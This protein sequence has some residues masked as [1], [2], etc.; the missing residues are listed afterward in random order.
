MANEEILELQIRD[1]AAYAAQGLGELST[2]LDKLKTAVGK[3]LRLKGVATQLE[4]LKNAVNSGLNEDS[5]ARFE[6]LAGVLERLKGIGAIKIAGI[7]NIASQMN[8]TDSLNDAKEQAIDTANTIAGAVDRGM[9]EVESRSTSVGN[10]LRETFANAGQKIKEVV[11]SIKDAVK[12][13]Y[14]KPGGFLNELVGGIKK[15]REGFKG[16][17]SDFMRIVKYRMIRS[18]IK[19]ITQAFTEG[20]KN[21]YFYSKEVGGTLAPAMDD[22]AS[23]LLQFKNSIGAA[24]SPLI[25]ELIPVLKTVVN[26]A[27]TG[28]NWLNQLF[29][30]MRGQHS[31]TKAIYK[32]TNAFDDQSKKAKKAGNSIKELLADWDELN[33]IQSESG[34]GNGGAAQAADDYTKMFE[35]E[36]KFDSWLSEHFHDVLDMIKAAGVALLGWKL[37]KNFTGVLGKLSKLIAGGAM[38]ALGIKLSFESGFDAGLN[39]FNTGNILGMI[40]G[41][42]ASGIGGYMITSAIGL[43]GGIGLAIGLG[44]GIVAS[45]YGYIK[46]KQDLADKSKWGNLT[47]TQ[48]QIERF[49]KNQF[50]FDIESEITIFDGAITNEQEAKEILNQKIAAFKSSLDNA[51]VEAKINIDSDE[52]SQ[53]VKDAAEKGIEAIGAV[54]QLVNASGEGLNVMLKSFKFTNDAGDDITKELLSSVEIANTTVES[55]FMGIGDELAR[56][57][58]QGEHEHWQNADT[59]QAVLD[60]L[61]RERRIMDEAK[62]YMNEIELDTSIRAGM[63][64]VVDR[65]TAKNVLEEQKKQLQDYEDKAMALYR[66]QASSY[67]ERAGLALAAADDADKIGDFDSAKQLR[68]AAKRYEDTAV[69]ILSEAKTN[70]DD[71]LADT[72]TEMADEGTK[73]LNAVYGGDFKNDVKSYS[74]FLSNPYYD[75]SNPLNDLI[76]VDKIDEAGKLLKSTLINYFTADDPNGIVSYVLNDLQGNV[77]DLLDKEMKQQLIDSLMRMT[78]NDKEKV[79]AI[80]KEAFGVKYF[81]ELS[82]GT[83][84]QAKEAIQRAYESG[85][86]LTQNE[87]DNIIHHFGQDAYDRAMEELD[88]AFDEAVKPEWVVEPEL[89]VDVK[90]EDIRKVYD[91]VNDA[92]KNSGLE[93]TQDLFTKTF[94]LFS[95]G[96]IESLNQLQ[97]YIDLNG[98]KD[99]FDRLENYMNGNGWVTGR[100]G[101][102]ALASTGVSSIGK[103][104]PT[105]ID[106]SAGTDEKMKTNIEDGM[107]AANQEQNAIL[108]NILIGVNAMLRK[109]WNVNLMPSAT[110]GFVNGAAAVAASKISGDGP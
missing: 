6:R 63:S 95:K 104:T 76:G 59:K 23:V 96:D 74:S 12:A 26:W 34:A 20:T 94:D 30:L 71:K 77:Y 33:I 61:E 50:S 49:V 69:L 17:L 42:L 56:L 16:M 5:V 110:L 52:T 31:W 37:S 36:T 57:I 103:Y 79:N 93:N 48:E 81:A 2:A 10:T 99:A 19:Q 100:L 8:V 54:N 53:S 87:I 29:A 41:V 55:Y 14:E 44:V 65:D 13:S 38:V 108:N 67:S 92:I 39:G 3:G 18:I 109:Q 21:V 106:A 91:D 70:I 24:V 83:I 68:D 80:W 25:Q 72:R 58:E 82:N 90:G 1:N 7:K 28:I 75:E 66:E 47:L 88:I 89:V 105:T 51:N 32:A 43:G 107:K 4:T 22:A 40:G 84:Q 9:E 97:Q 15:A 27:I 102:G 101:N 64:T 46:G 98:V 73:T 45:L 78:G 85:G 11:G 60:L 62:K 35:E 86:E